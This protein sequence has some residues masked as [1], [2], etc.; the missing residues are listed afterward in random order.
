MASH[1]STTVNPLP[2]DVSPVRVPKRLSFW[3]II[4]LIAGGEVAN[5]VAGLECRRQGH[6]IYIIG[7]S[8]SQSL[9][10]K[11]SFYKPQMSPF[12]GA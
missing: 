6:N 2:G 5:L 7:G 4:V 10:S 1:K 8:P 12:G 11:T 9:S 3:D